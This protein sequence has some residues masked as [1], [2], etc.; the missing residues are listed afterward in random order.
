M[1]NFSNPKTF[2]FFIGLFFLLFTL[3]VA[4][5]EGLSLSGW[6]VTG[7]VLLMASW[8]AT[9]ALPLPVTALVP[10]ALFP[11][12]GIYDLSDA[13]N[14]AKS[15]FTKA[16]APY[17]HPN[18]FLFLGGFILALAIE[19]VNLHKRI[20]LK[21]LLSIG[22]DAK[23]LIG[24]FMLVSALISMWIMNTSTTLM[25]LPIGLAIAGVVRKTTN[26]EKDFFNFQTALLLGIAYAATIGGI[27]TPVG[28]APNIVVISLIQEQGLEI[29]FN[30]WMLLALPISAIMLI[31][32]WWLLTNII[33][34]VK[35]DANEKTQNSLQKMYL[36]LGVISIDEKRVLVIF[37]LT[38]L[39]WMFR[40]LL[41]NTTLLQGLT[42]YGIAIIAALAVFITRSSQGSGLVEWSITTKLPWGILILFG[43][44]L[45]MANAIMS[46]GLGKWIGGLIPDINTVF[47]IL[48]IVVLIV[49]LTE[50]TSNQAT[51]A[52]FVPIMII[53]ATVEGSLLPDGT[54][55]LSL[56]AQLAIPVA[57]AASCAFMLPVA[58]PPNAIVYG[59]E[60]F[61]IAQ[62]MK[63]G[64][65][66]NILGILVVT[67][68]SVFVL[69]L[70]F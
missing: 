64:L 32:G 16:A 13:S 30:Q 62:M 49:F 8:W 3:L 20:A 59:S 61:T 6:H 38:A 66:F 11:L 18:V 68:F 14:P 51:T 17:A 43:G 52:T 45:S 27:S 9:E 35:I 1:K 33:F 4:P 56:V 58:T 26:L 60:K 37:V 28:T 57:L 44:G 29:S 36:D 19:K 65:Y 48:L 7:V 40:D 42:D 54:N 2:G 41:D 22:T 34:P 21:M 55:N 31:V 10:L 23:Y 67:A 5:P 63:A 12:L 69:P 47:L 53:L 50:L 70:I 25:L 46:S 24:G 15:A 39:A